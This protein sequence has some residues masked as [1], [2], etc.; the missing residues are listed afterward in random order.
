MKNLILILCVLSC[1]FK[2]QANKYHLNE[3]KLDAAFSKSIDLTQQIGIMDLNSIAMGLGTSKAAEE[4]S[5]QTAAAIVGVIQ[6]VTGIGILIPIHRFILGTAGKG[7]VVFLAYCGV[8]VVTLGTGSWLMT[9]VDV[10]FLFTD[11]TKNAYV[12]NG[13]VL[14]WSDN[15]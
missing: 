15:V 6:L 3:V 11:D 14:M 5:K 2:A 8:G 10:I 7:A 13:K 12:N 1:G 9:L 4:G